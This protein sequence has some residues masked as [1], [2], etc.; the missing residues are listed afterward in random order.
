MTALLGYVIEV[1]SEKRQVLDTRSTHNC[2][3]WAEGSGHFT[4]RRHAEAAW[5]G[6]PPVCEQCPGKG[7]WLQLQMP[8]AR[9]HGPLCHSPMPRT[10]VATWQGHT[11]KTTF[12]LFL[13]LHDEGKL[14]ICLQC[15]KH[16]K[17]AMSH[18]LNI[19]TTK[20]RIKYCRTKY[21]FLKHFFFY[22]F[23][24]ILLWKHD[25]CATVILAVTQEQH[26]AVF[27]S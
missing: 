4:S 27:F 6:H 1:R 17:F 13:F 3:Q 25:Q 20:N 5:P 16:S 11:S 24:L 15:S 18:K 21:G 2:V 9:S 26:T 8:R 14:H 23:T 22:L 10:P 7:T 12:R 19:K